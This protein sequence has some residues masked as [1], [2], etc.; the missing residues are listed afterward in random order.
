MAVLKARRN[1]EQAEEKMLRLKKWQQVFD[2]RTAP[3]LRQLD[4][5]FFLVS[6]H[7]PKGIHSL[8]ERIKALQ[9]YAEKFPTAKSSTAAEPGTAETGGLS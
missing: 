6:Q 2:N 8:G 3:L 4:P 9:D 7:L 5:A 1:L